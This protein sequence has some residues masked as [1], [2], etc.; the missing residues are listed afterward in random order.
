[1]GIPVNL[2]GCKLI[3]TTRSEKVCKQMD[4]QHKIK[5]KPLCEREAWTLF[6]EKLG[7]DK[8]LSLEVEQIAVYVARECAG[9]PCCNPFLGPHK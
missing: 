1:M 2:K 7:D 9:L 3:M 8:A 5:L 6:M 4:S